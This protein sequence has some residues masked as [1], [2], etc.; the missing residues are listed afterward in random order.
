MASSNIA[1]YKEMFPNFETPGEVLRH[2]NGREIGL[3]RQ[4]LTKITNR[5][6]KILAPNQSKFLEWPH[7]SDQKFLI[8]R[9]KNDKLIIGRK[10]RSLG[11]GSHGMVFLF[12]VVTEPELMVA[13][14][15]DAMSVDNM[16]N[17]IH[18]LQLLYQNRKESRLEGIQDAIHSTFCVKKKDLW[19]SEKEFFYEF[20]YI[21]TFYKEGAAEPLL[22]PIKKDAALSVIRQV[23]TGLATAHRLNLLHDDIKIDNLLVRKEDDS[24]QICLADWGLAREIK[25]LTP[26]QKAMDVTAL[27]QTLYEILTGITIKD[28]SNPCT[29]TRQQL[30]DLK[31]AH[32]QDQDFFGPFEGDRLKEIEIPEQ[33]ITLFEKVIHWDLKSPQEC[34]QAEDFAL[35]ATTQ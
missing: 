26:H 3:T 24:W 10:V 7:H 29:L 27:C 32:G 18:A 2:K 19:D 5:A 31:S 8:T 25:D 11:S 23:F 14:F 15:A 35:L 6:F 28:T 4:E 9:G 22:A 1:I 17:E 30:T 21:T 13:K 12:D 20:G 34:P 16:K 33:V